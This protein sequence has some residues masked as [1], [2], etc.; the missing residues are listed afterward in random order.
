MAGILLVI[1]SARRAGGESEKAEGKPQA[2]RRFRGLTVGEYHKQP[3]EPE[4]I[5]R[6]GEMGDFELWQNY[7]PSCFEGYGGGQ[8]KFTEPCRRS[9]NKGE[10]RR[11]E[12]GEGSLWEGERI[13]RRS[14]LEP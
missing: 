4:R 12:V 1:L 7:T 11:F 5:F 8:A 10:G 6:E 3:I 2:F 14:R 13:D 9:F